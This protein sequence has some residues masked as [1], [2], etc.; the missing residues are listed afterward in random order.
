M[1]N[2]ILDF[3]RNR[4]RLVARYVRYNAYLITIDFVE[5]CMRLALGI[6]GPT[7]ERAD[8]ESPL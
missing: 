7:G 5:R 3:Q 4:T 2:V 8:D 1:A 6:I